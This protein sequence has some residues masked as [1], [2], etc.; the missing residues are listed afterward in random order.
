M[1]VHFKKIYYLLK[2]IGNQLWQ[3][4]W[5]LSKIMKVA[6]VLIIVALLGLGYYA[7]SGKEVIPEVESKPRQVSLANVGDLSDNNSPIPLVGSVTSVSEATIRAESSGKLTRVYRKLGDRV[8]AGQIIASF[9]NSGESAAVLSAE[10][11]YESAKAARDIALINSA[12]TNLTLSDVKANTINTINSTFTTLDDI[13]HAK[14][15]SAFNDARF[16]NVT[17]KFLVPDSLLTARVESQRRDIEAMLT[18]MEKSNK[19]L[20]VNDDLVAKLD[21]TQR[22]VQKIKMYLD[23][24]A[25]VYVKAISS[26]SFS[27]SSIEAQKSIVSASRSTISATLSSLTNAKVTLSNSIASGDIAGR[28]T[29]DANPNTASADAGVK[30]ALGAYNA[31]L[32]RLEKTIIRSPITGTL[33]SLS[34]E[35]GDFISQGTQVAVVSNNGALEV[36]AYVSEDDSKRISVGSQATIN[37]NIKGVITRIASA[38]DPTT[39]KIEVKVGILDE[40]SNLINGESVRLSV[41]NTPSSSGALQMIKIPLSAIKITPRGSFVFTLSATSSLQSVTVETGALLGEE[42]E[43]KN[44]LTRDMSI[45]RDARGLKEGV[46]VDA[47]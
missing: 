36:Q 14:T 21:E 45:I 19:T 43:I 44:G 38:V 22:N 30:S 6:V 42:I 3:W 26:E 31:A 8:S 23:D 2:A 39:R 47:K 5:E 10:G 4:F 35:T 16:S 33:N 13:I 32:S 46:V 25:N 41:Q 29:G 28:T 17:V 11:A 12:N 24:L 40:K 1:N 37:G 9:E 18:Q 15:D 20:S 27:D 34:I 7:L